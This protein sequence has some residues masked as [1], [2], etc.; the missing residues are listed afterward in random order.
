MFGVWLVFTCHYA[1]SVVYLTHQSR[2]SNATSL[3]VR[4]DSWWFAS[5]HQDTE[6]R[7]KKAAS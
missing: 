1:S 6:I 2:A 3:G 7:P 5:S 4:D